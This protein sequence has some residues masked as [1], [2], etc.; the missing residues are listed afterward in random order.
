MPKTM[1]HVLKANEVQFADPL[2][3]SLDPA[4]PPGTGGPTPT[5]QPAHIRIAESHPEYALVEV[6]CSCGRT[7]FVRC[8]Y[9]PAQA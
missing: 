2:Q 1:R 8:D 7:T 3:L 4:A 6:T 5:S 9:A